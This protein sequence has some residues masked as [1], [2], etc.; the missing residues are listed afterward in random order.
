MA[1]SRRAAKAAKTAKATKAPAT[2]RTARAAATEQPLT[3]AEQK[4]TVAEERL[5]SDQTMRT[6]GTTPRH[7]EPLGPPA[8]GQGGRPG[9]ERRVTPSS[10]VGEVFPE[11]T[12]D[13]IM[14]KREALGPEMIVRATRTGYLDDARRREGDVF[15]IRQKQFS[16]KWMV[17]V[18]GSTPL[19]TT[20]NKAALKKFHDETLAE[21]A[22]SKA[23]TFATSTGD[24]D[25]LER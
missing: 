17:P 5:E 18:D 23:K 12:V 20:S 19:K 24:E 2:A 11:P 22:G 6:D 9:P 4:K 15:K 16:S 13:E 21:R 7:Q 10:G 3:E 14:A 1:K 25:V 8:P